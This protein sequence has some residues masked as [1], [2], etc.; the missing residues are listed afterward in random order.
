MKKMF[1]VLALTALF[2]PNCKK[3]DSTSDS[4]SCTLS[5]ANIVGTYMLTGS[6]YQMPSS[7][8][9]DDFPTFV[10]CSKDD[11]MIIKSDGTV[12]IDDAGT[13]CNPTT[14][15]TAQWS[16]NSNTLILGTTNGTTYTVKSFDCKGMTLVTSW[17]P[18]EINTKI[19]TRL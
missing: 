16:L 9:V 12:V 19:F 7:P 11:K 15:V 6:T 2:F 18:G 8:V 17:S 10:A 14:A 4:G 1:F 5:K 13:V 3:N